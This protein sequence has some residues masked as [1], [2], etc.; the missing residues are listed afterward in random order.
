MAWV[1]YASPQSLS[2]RRS[3]RRLNVSSGTVSG[4]YD[5]VNT[6]SHVYKG[7]QDRLQR[8][9]VYDQM[10]KDSDV[11]RALDL[12]A[13]HIVPK[14][15]KTEWPFRFKYRAEENATEEVVT[16]LNEHM[17]YWMKLN[18]LEDRVRKNVRSCLKYGDWFYWRNPRTFELYNI[19]PRLVLGA[20]VD[21]EKLEVLAWVVRGVKFNTEDMEMVPDNPVYETLRQNL[22]QSSTIH[23]VKVIPAINIIHLSLSEGK[24]S[25]LGA[26]DEPANTMVTRWPFGESILEPMY[27]T[28]KQRELMEDASLIHRIQRAPTRRVWYID[29]GKNRADRAKWIINDFRN[30]MNQRR[31]PQTFGAEGRAMDSI[32]NPQSTLEDYYI[33]VTA[34]GRGSKVE[35]L[36]GQPW[37]DIPELT[38]MTKKMLRALRIPYSMWVGPDEGGSLFSDGKTGTAY[39]PEIEFS[40]FCA[41]IQQNLFKEFDFEFKLFC[42]WTDV[43]I[44]ASDFEVRLNPPTN[45]EVYLKNMRDQDNITIWSQVKDEQSLSKRLAWELYMGWDKETFIKNERYFVEDN[46]P[47]D[48]PLQDDAAGMGGA[49]PMGGPMGGAL[50]PPPAGADGMD[51]MGAG[52]MGGGAMGSTAGM[53][54]LGGPAAPPAPAMAGGMGEAIK[55][56]KITLT[57]ED[58]AVS[59]IEPAPLKQL[60]KTGIYTARTADDSSFMSDDPIDPRPKITLAMIRDLRRMH[61]QRRIEKQK[62]LRVVRKVYQ[63]V[64]DAAAGG[65]PPL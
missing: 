5:N 40:E 21:Q 52:D 8:Y 51:P 65:P 10:D 19:H 50:P 39:M 64:G 12:M 55:M 9:N 49:G 32:Y 29:V 4:G 61:M 2:R 46:Y 16:V 17:A 30:E 35:N 59:D 7:Q 37:N 27:K 31:I 26:D 13:R 36:E 56:N 33:P 62:R 3:V 6:L 53:D 15:K 60:P 38:Y 41:S 22:A 57:E 43:P 24:F 14:E 44:N 47:F 45:Y 20:M 11:N 1:T 34:E 18:D 54:S 42:K 28:Y 23:D 48:N 63:R 25:G 58:L